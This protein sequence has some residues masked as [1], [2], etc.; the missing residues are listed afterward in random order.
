MSKA[1]IVGRHLYRVKFRYQ[2]D[3]L[4]F[5]LDGNL[6]ITTDARGLGPAG[7]ATT[8]VMRTAAFRKKFPGAIVRDIVYLGTIDS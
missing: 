8:A 7:R 6:N 1:K 3:G 4:Y 2:T 5:L